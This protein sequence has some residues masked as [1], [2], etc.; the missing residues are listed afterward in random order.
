MRYLFILL[1]L[2]I[3]CPSLASDRIAPIYE[4]NTEEK[5]LIADKVSN[6]FFK[7]CGLLAEEHENIVAKYNLHESNDVGSK[8]DEIYVVHVSYLPNDLTSIFL[9][10]KTQ[11]SYKFLYL[12]RD[13]K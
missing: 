11:D 5:A 9:Y 3:G 6:I 7:K 2:A 10:N 1:L 12:G 8:D 4:P 13:C